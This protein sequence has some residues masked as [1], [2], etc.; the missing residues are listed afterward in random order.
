[1]D[2]SAFAP[3]RPP[4]AGY[5]HGAGSASDGGRAGAQD[6]PGR[7]YGPA[8]LAG[9]FDSLDL[10][11]PHSFD[12]FHPPNSSSSAPSSSNARAPL[13]LSRPP[14]PM[15]AG[16]SYQPTLGLPNG[17]SA[18]NRPRPQ[19]SPG[20][21]PSGGVFPPR[22][23][24]PLPHPGANGS[25]APRVPRKSSLPPIPGQGAPSS[26]PA[27]PLPPLPP[28]ASSSSSQLSVDSFGP[29]D[30]SG[31][32]QVFNG[33]AI[34]A[35]TDDDTSRTNLPAG[36]AAAASASTA[37]GNAALAASGSL[38]RANPLEDLIA[39]ET[40]YVEDLGAV[41]KRVAAAWSRDNFPPPA[42]DAMFRAIEAVYRINKT[43]LEK[44][45]EI[46]PNPSSPKALGDLLMRWI[47]DIEPAYTR[48]A[49]TI[50][51]DFDLY[52]PVQSNPKL[53]PI[54]SSLPW[55][56][57]LPSPPSS[58]TMDRLFELPYYRVRYYKR[59]YAK[60]L[61]STQE[62]RSDHA[63]LPPVLEQRIPAEYVERLASP[64]IERRE[65]VQP[66]RAG[67]PR[68]NLDLSAAATTLRKG[69]QRSAVDS[70]RMESP[71]SS[72]FRSSG[73]T[74]ISTANTSAV[75]A[76]SPNPS[77][78]PPL[79][80]SELERR[81]NTE[82]T[83]D[84]FTMKPR[85]CKLQMQ[86]PNLVYQRQLRKASE[87]VMS[88][89]PTSDPAQRPVRIP[90]AFVI[91]LTDL[92]LICEYVAPEEL[93][94]AGGA[95]LW[96]L[97]PPLAGK[98]LRVVEGPNRG[99]IEVTIM[100]KERLTFHV[101]GGD[102]VRAKELKAAIEEAARFGATQPRQDSTMSSGA[103][104]SPISPTSPNS[105]LSSSF[106]PMPGQ[107]LSPPPPNAHPASPIPPSPLSATSRSDERSVFPH[108]G[109]PPLGAVRPPPHHQPNPPPFDPSRRAVSG[110]APSIARPERNASMTQRGYPAPSPTYANGQVVQ[111]PVSSDFRHTNGSQGHPPHHRDPY[112]QPDYRQPGTYST[113]SGRQSPHGPQ[114]SFPQSDFGQYAPPHA[115]GAYPT[116]PNGM[117]RSQSDL[118]PPI[119]AGMPPRPDSR[120]SN[121]SYSSGRTDNSGRWPAA[122]PPLPKERSFNGMDF[123][124]R[125]GPLYATSL[126]SEQGQ[127]GFLA[128]PQ[129][130]VHR[131]RSADGL[132]SDALRGAMNP[133]P[134][135]RA[136]SQALIE[137]RSTSAPGSSRSGSKLSSRHHDDVS[138][139]TSPVEP[140]IP[141]KTSVVATM[142]C[143]VFLQQ[144]HAQW[145]SLGTAKLKLFQS[146]PSNT[147]QLV[148]DSDKGGGKTII[149]TIVLADGVERVGKTGV[150]IDLS[151]QGQRTGII[152][153]L[154]L[155]TEQSATGLFEQLLLGTDRAGR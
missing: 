94:V 54:L 74:G 30:S 131:S 7:S 144:H 34:A 84:I 41:I 135:Y 142:R 52:E 132:R 19:L 31:G 87:A 53:A 147:K 60:L 61:R 119:M 122:P 14:G 13:T 9:H 118:A 137:E 151:D 109:P 149:S 146:M 6:A 15:Q 80:V 141:D 79:H 140:R 10:S 63:L 105:A 90:R 43:L 29:R 134:N 121:G 27:P 39:T 136:P 85:K 47:S 51:L 35:G 64:P 82:R 86:P 50:S 145:K 123:S 107:S 124:G 126:R 99:E 32:E 37:S 49:T 127:G 103:G 58:V 17:Y 101:E 78:E 88:F 96:L 70:P 155:R 92:F 75:H 98:H 113:G 21:S 129:G 95:D 22:S 72:S 18:A 48:Y 38:K 45:H 106:G 139:P 148:V 102:E 100:N 2:Y 89:V 128:A 153:M 40:A 57:S 23:T 125:G 56:P 44:L 143:K 104:H 36:H 83:L 25:N 81:L 1:M 46:G 11:D 115:N 59:L 130:P 24:S 133:S 116:Y 114:G 117:P 111:S 4:Q 68:L 20:L 108:P 8:G 76:P 152:Y 42:L 62:G 12:A 55:P 16:P 110:P 112:G 138:P 3:A 97:Y 65:V 77:R 120:Q 73:A 71:S 69:E 5:S 28:S 26:G 67:P 33:A 93:H 150:A 66:E 154:Q 91:I